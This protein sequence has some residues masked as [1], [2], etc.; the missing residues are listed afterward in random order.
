M[1]LDN[2]VAIVTGGGRGIGRGIA[3]LFAKEGA[4]V[5][6]NYYNSDSGAK[7]TVEEIKSFGGEAIAVKADVSNLDDI[8]N[9]K[10]N[11]VYYSKTIEIKSL[12]LKFLCMND[13]PRS[14]K[15]GSYKT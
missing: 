6:V 8:K 7:E 9:L 5:V 13:F 2:K 12:L 10:E 1:K 15:P 3:K 14:Y 4:K 11:A